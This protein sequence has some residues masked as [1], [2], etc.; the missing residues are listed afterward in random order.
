VWHT[1]F[2][3]SNVFFIA[4]NL[5]VNKDTYICLI[6]F[7]LISGVSIEKHALPYFKIFGVESNSKE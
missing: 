4:Y 2:S 6:L 5:V 1:Q 3:S 7:S